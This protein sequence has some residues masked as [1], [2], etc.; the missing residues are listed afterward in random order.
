[1]TSTPVTWYGRPRT[2]IKSKM[3]DNRKSVGE[4]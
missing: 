2:W 1:M 3:I 4:Y